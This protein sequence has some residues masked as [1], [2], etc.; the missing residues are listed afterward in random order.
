LIKRVDRDLANGSITLISAN[1]AYEP[2]KYSG[3]ELDKINI[4][5]LV[6]ACWHKL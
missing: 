4:V 1:K 6:V 2:R 3:N 5:G